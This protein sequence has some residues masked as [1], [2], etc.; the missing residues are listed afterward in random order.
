MMVGQRFRRMPRFQPLQRIAFG[1]QLLLGIDLGGQVGGDGIGHH[2][3][4]LAGSDDC[5]VVLGWQG[6]V[7]S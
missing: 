5:D 7:G 3:P 1:Q 2:Q 6:Q 4:H